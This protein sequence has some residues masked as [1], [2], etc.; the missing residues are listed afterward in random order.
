MRSLE[1]KMHFAHVLRSEDCR[2]H[3]LM[4]LLKDS[5][6]DRMVIPLEIVMALDIVWP[7][8]LANSLPF[9]NF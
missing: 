7:P 4:L 9:Y 5:V 3:S 8:D 6:C 1:E 2:L